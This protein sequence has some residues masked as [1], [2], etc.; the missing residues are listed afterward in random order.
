MYANQK[1]GFRGEKRGKFNLK[2]QRKTGSS[3][4]FDALLLAAI[5][6]AFTCLGERSKTALYVCL[7]Q[8]LGFK[9]CD[10][11]V[12]LDD[13]SHFLEKLLGVGAQQLEIMC[14]KRLHAKLRGLCGDDVQGCPISDVTFVSYVALKKKQFENRK[15]TV[16]IGMLPFPETV[17]AKKK[18]P[19]G[20]I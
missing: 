1:S 14:M 3:K 20:N 9:A 11:P 2:K 10:I 6:E 16:E 4:A 13:F 15:D 19:T 12:R 7:E 5:D 17:Y 18:D 8:D